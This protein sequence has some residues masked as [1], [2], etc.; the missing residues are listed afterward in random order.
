MADADKLP[1]PIN[2]I[3]LDGKRLLNELIAETKVYC[4]G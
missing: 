4:A 2:D 1:V 3:F